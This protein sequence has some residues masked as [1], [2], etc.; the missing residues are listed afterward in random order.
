MNSS[1]SLLDLAD[2]VRGVSYKRDE[3]QAAPGPGFVPVVRANN[4]RD[5]HLVL[6][7][8]VYVPASRVSSAQRIRC[9]DIVLAMSSGS[10]DVVGKAAIARQ[11]YDAGF[12]AFC[13]VLRVKSGTRTEWLAHFMRSPV[14]R[15]A[16]AEVITGTN[17]NN[18]SKTT[19]SAV[20]LPKMS[21]DAQDRL[22]PF[23]DQMDSRESTCGAHLSNARRAI[24]R[25][26][27]A[28][29]VAACSGRLTAAWRD[30]N[31]L[32]DM[33]RLLGERAAAGQS[34]TRRGVAPGAPLKPILTELD[35]PANWARITVSR[36][37]VLGILVDVKDGNHGANH[38]KVNE[39]T[40]S[41]IPFIAANLVHD[42]K[43]DY[44]NAPRVSGRPLEHLRIGFAK[45]DDVILTHKGSVGRVA[46]ADRD[47]VL[48]PQTTYYRCDFELILP[49]YLAI[50][51]QSLYFY[52]QLAEEMSQTTRDFVPISDQYL[53]G[54]ILPPPDEQKEIVRRAK[55]LLALSDA[56]NGRIAAASQRVERSSLA[57]L[58]KAFR[59][60]FVPPDV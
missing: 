35:L 54:L 50:Y 17:I 38:P 36:A 46:I 13:G 7:D 25:F 2:L 39:F 5:G 23:L 51:L 55:E 31:T 28:A 60:D 21:E 18:L 59:G 34:K 1:S 58:S 42:G 4:I 8:L 3:A 48:T 19:L 37:L 24:E 49:E 44:D 11:N 52:L 9:G 30:D 10:P 6:D 29:L 15:S 43:I 22:V 32:Q 53:L 45:P 14:Y 47:C 16:I 33:N 57:L 40:P 56:V 41:G 26:R 27:Q 12:G 20:L